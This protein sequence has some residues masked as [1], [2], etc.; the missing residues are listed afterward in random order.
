MSITDKIKY[1]HFFNK[2]GYKVSR[3]E[4]VET[5][6]FSEEKEDIIIEVE[7]EELGRKC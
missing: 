4:G 3:V 7:N 2:A 5:R 1:E 6:Y